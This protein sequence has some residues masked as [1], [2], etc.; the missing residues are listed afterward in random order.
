MFEK[1]SM[2]L[3]LDQAVLSG[4]ENNDK[5]KLSGKELSSLLKHGAY[6]ALQSSSDA[7]AARFCEDDIDEILSR[8]KKITTHSSA[9]EK[10]A[11]FSQAHFA[12]QVCPPPPLPFLSAPSLF[13]LAPLLSPRSHHHPTLGAP[14]RWVAP[15]S[16]STTPSFGLR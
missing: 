11:S 14:C 6:G 3:G 12:V 16:P 4:I 8:S 9:A 10:G 5:K 7:D 1:A 13:T 2:K 15:T